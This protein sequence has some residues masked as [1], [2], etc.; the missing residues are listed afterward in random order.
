MRAG[1]SNAPFDHE[2]ALEAGELFGTDVI[3]HAIV[4]RRGVVSFRSRRLL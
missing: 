3:N 4:A 2:A 1:V